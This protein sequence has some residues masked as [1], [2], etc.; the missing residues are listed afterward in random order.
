MSGVKICNEKKAQ[1]SRTCS[2]IRKLSTS[3]ITITAVLLHHLWCKPLK[4]LDT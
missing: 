1:K 3:E 4:I 2:N